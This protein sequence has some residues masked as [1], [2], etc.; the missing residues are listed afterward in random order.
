MGGKLSLIAEFPDREPVVL[1]GIASLDARWVRGKCGFCTRLT[2]GVGCWRECYPWSSTARTRGTRGWWWNGQDRTLGHPPVAHSHDP[3]YSLCMFNRRHS[4]NEV[5]TPRR[6]EVNREIYVDRK[7]LEKELR[8]SLD[9]ALHTVIFG[10]SGSGKSW[11]YKKVL[12]DLGAKIATANCANALRFHSLTEEIRQVVAQENPKRLEELSEE[13]NAS[14]KAVVAEGG[15][16]STRKYSFAETDPLLVC[17]RLL[18]EKAGNKLAVLVIDNLEMIFS[19]KDRMD[20][21]AAIITL[22]DDN[23]YAEYKVKLLVVGVPSDI[24]DYLAK[25]HASVSNRISEVSEVSSLSKEEVAILVEK[26]FV[27]LLKTDIDNSTLK[28]WQEHI[29]VVTMGF[30]QPVQEYCEQL[31]YKLEDVDWKASPELLKQ[32]DTA[33]LKKGL[34]QASGMI[35]PLMN[36]RETKL[37]RRNQV[38]FALGKVNKRVF[39]ANEIETILRNEFPSSTADV[40]LAVGQILSELTGGDSPII[41]RSSK[42]PTYEFKDARYAMA[43]RVLLQKDS[44]KEIVTKVE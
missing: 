25:G 9:G 1:A 4:V 2:W 8:R 21:L 30:A 39:H 17:F 13:M 43:L 19:S 44:H 31:G 38:L 6:N 14:V 37:G 22:L 26:G 24:K 20:E 42:G 35:V 16:K 11:L 27:T 33:W 18:R 34:S 41:K 10:E 3:P 5:F 36:E 32:A 29:Y 23:R 40:S 12:A 28:Y 7:E 15:L